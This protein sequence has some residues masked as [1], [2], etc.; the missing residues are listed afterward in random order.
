MV[1]E[2]SEAISNTPT[3][4]LQGSQQ[5]KNKTQGMRI[6]LK[7]LY[8]KISP[9]WKRKQLNSRGAKNPIQDKPKEKHAKK[10]TNQTN[11]D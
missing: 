9:T 4:K 11:K 6:F 8:L 10:H 2:V 1:S 3:F 7:R 5:K